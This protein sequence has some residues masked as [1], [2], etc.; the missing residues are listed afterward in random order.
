MSKMKGHSTSNAANM[1]KIQ[2]LKISDYEFTARTPAEIENSRKKGGPGNKKN[3]GTP[4]KKAKKEKFVVDSPNES[5]DSDDTDTII[6][7]LDSEQL[8]TF[9]NI[10]GTKKKKKSSSSS[11]K[12]RK[13]ILLEKM[14]DL[15]K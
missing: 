4:L 8:K 9:E 5:D 14:L 10:S 11:S 6:S 7:K 1:K 2:F 3:G 13:L 15:L 12:E